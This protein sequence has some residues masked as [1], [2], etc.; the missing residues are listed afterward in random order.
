MTL[1]SIAAP[2]AN[3][4]PAAERVHNIADEYLYLV[5]AYAAYPGTGKRLSS[6]ESKSNYQLMAAADDEG[7]GDRDDTTQQPYPLGEC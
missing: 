6:F 7:A 1:T 5:G 3:R 2:I 4:I